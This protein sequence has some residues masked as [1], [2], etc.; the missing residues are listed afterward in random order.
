MNDYNAL[1]THHHT[2]IIVQD[3]TLHNTLKDRF[4]FSISRE[5]RAAV[6]IRIGFEP[7]SVT[8][9]EAWVLPR[10]V[11]L[12]VSEWHISCSAILFSI[13]ILMLRSLPTQITVSILQCEVW[14]IPLFSRPSVASTIKDSVIRGKEALDSEAQ[15]KKR[16]L[17]SEI[18]S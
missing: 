16:D 14:H 1:G 6:T 7:E 15:K 4:Y 2:L 3:F 18:I 8:D 10:K 17:G 9:F 13:L 5:Q 12:C 11:V